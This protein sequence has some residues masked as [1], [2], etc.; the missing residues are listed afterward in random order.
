MCVCVYVNIND[1]R[2]FN[3]HYT[4]IIKILF[5]ASA[6]QKIHLQAYNV[7]N[8]LLFQTN[9]TRVFTQDDKVIINISIIS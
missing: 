8:K 1:Y 7:N 3:A 2:V 9:L 6:R 4:L 5:T